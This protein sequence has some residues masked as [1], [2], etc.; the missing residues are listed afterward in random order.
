[1]AFRTSPPQQTTLGSYYLHFGDLARIL[2][3]TLFGVLDVSAENS[4][5][6]E[7]VA[8]F[9][10]PLL[11]LRS[12]L[13]NGKKERRN[14]NANVNVKHGK[15]GPTNRNRNENENE[16]GSAS[17]QRIREPL[18]TTG[19]IQDWAL[20]LKTLDAVL[21]RVRTHGF[22]SS[23]YLGFILGGDFSSTQA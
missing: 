17:V 2:N 5:S 14:V 11:S 21:D 18:K 16:N 6:G 20:H 9:D 1:M 23:L 4:L 15:T 3:Q 19:Q 10:L 13:S 22:P 8:Q 12:K 7:A